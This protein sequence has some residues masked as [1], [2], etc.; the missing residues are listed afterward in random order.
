MTYPDQRRTSSTHKTS[1]PD[2]EGK[3]SLPQAGEMQVRKGPRGLLRSSSKHK[4]SS[5]GPRKG[6]DHQ[7]LANAP[8]ISR[9]TGIHRIPQLLLEIHRR[10]LTNSETLHDLTKKDTVF[11]WNDKCR[12]AFEELKGRITSTPILA[13]ARDTG[14][15]RIEANTCQFTTRGVLSQEQEGVFQPIAFFSQSLNETERNYDI[16]NR[17]LLGIMKAL[18]E[19]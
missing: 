17:E 12:M 7:R 2:T 16:Y 14:L 18:K 19:W 11:M 5:N 9:S 6:E 15:M 13:M 8:K 3:P 4:W 1:T 10:V